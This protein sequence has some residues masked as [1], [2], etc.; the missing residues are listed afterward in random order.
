MFYEIT[1]EIEKTLEN[2]LT[3]KVK[4][5]YITDCEFFTEAENKAIEHLQCFNDGEI[6]VTAIKRSKVIEIVNEIESDF[7][8]RA[9]VVQTKLDDNGNEKEF[10]YQLLVPAPDINKATILMNNHLQQGFDDM[11]LDALVKTKIIEVI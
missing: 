6:D 4:E 11:R 3:K 7:F 2:G 10:K 8:F 9:T 5:Q 1:A